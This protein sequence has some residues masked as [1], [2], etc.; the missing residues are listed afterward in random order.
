MTFILFCYQV[1]IIK[2]LLILI[3]L[4]YFYLATRRTLTLTLTLQL[5]II[6][7]AKST[8]KWSQCFT[9]STTSIF[10]TS[11]SLVSFPIRLQWLYHHCKY[12]TYH[13]HNWLRSSQ[14]YITH[15]M[16]HPHYCVSLWS[17]HLWPARF[18][19]HKA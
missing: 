8:F 14:E 13:I 9:R 2:F 18:H 7:C 1:L 5:L 10:Q 11:F 3:F 17:L 15:P 19:L 12:H 16:N 4:Q 6:F